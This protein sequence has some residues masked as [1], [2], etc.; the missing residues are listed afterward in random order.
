MFF[1]MIAITAMMMAVM[2]ASPVSAGEISEAT[3]LQIACPEA[4]HVQLHDGRITWR[5]EDRNVAK[6]R[7]CLQEAYRTFV[8]DPFPVNMTGYCHAN[9]VSVRKGKIVLSC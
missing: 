9:K 5:S 6:A 1:R 4:E 8:T 2:A 7:R 3:R